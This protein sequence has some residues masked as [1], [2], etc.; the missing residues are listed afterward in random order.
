VEVPAVLSDPGATP[1]DLRFRLFGTYVRVHPFFWLV[2]IVLGWSWTKTP[3]PVLP[4]NG[5]GELALWVFCVFVSIL[6]HEFG[7]VWMGRLF[8]SEGHIVLYS[9]G[10]LAIGSNSLYRRWQRILVSFAGPG[11]QLLLWVALVALKLAGYWP[12]HGTPLEL[13]LWMLLL[14]NLF[15][16]LLNL[17]PIWPLD[18][19]MIS[20]EIFTGLSPSRGVI[21]SL[22]VSL[23]VAALIALDGFMSHYQQKSFLPSYIPR[24]GLF[25]AILFTLFA[26]DNFR[27][28]QEETSRGRYS[29]DDL[30]W[31]R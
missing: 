20:R 30:P 22:W 25:G 4:G 13:F 16:P 9:M 3:N 19:G 7:H 10:G 6:L 12:A 31:E 28:I 29:D 2:S 17:L 15:W 27:A 5:L 26:V 23:I 1:M 14:I 24:V 18:G 8:G 11:I 21:T